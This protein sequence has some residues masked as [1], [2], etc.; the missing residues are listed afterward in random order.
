MR[1]SQAP[2][3]RVGEAALRE[4]NLSRGSHRPQPVGEP[5]AFLSLI[6]ASQ[7]RHRPLPTESLMYEVMINLVSSLP[8]TNGI[9]EPMRSLG[10]YGPGSYHFRPHR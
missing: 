1:S 6:Q 8:T 4:N 7:L 10:G 9:V 2:E 5:A 3:K